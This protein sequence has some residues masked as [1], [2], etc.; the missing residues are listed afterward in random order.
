[1]I[2]PAKACEVRPTAPDPAVDGLLTLSSARILPLPSGGMYSGYAGDLSCWVVAVM[3][4]AVTAVSHA[5]SDVLAPGQ[6][7]ALWQCGTFTVQSVGDSVCMLVQLGGELPGR[8]LE[9]RMTDG[10]AFFPR[11]GAA[12]R[13][14]VLSLAVLEEESAPLNGTTAGAYA[15]TMLSHLLLGPASGGEEPAGQALTPLVEAAVGIIQA[16]FPFLEGLD[17]LAERLEVSKAHLI[18]TFTRQTGVS[19]GRYITHL[20]LE[21]AKLLLRGEDPSITYVAEASGFANANYFA[22]AFR[23]ETGMSPSEYMESIPQQDRKAASKREPF[24]W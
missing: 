4:G 2:D 5:R 13:E 14:A 1:M 23:R 8:L 7:L 12:V 15:Y 11:G 21:Y 20:R 10:A 6:A 9:R 19:P 17:E 18:R 3:E 22:K 16:E 24:L